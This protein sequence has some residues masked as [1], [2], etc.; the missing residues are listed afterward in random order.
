MP[1]LPP[2]LR[3]LDDYA[4]DRQS[5]SREQFLAAHG[6][7][8]L[9]VPMLSPLQDAERFSTLIVAN[10]AALAPASWAVAKVQKRAGDAFPHFIWVGREVKCD[11][12]LP[13]DGVSKLHAQF[14]LR[15]GGEIDLLDTGSANGTFL[16]G[17]RLQDN[18][19]LRV[20]DGAR[21]QMGMVEMAYRTPEGLWDALATWTPGSRP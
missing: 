14:I 17:K 12:A 20:R 9:I 18:A 13:F 6:T 2:G 4:R 3:P 21:I 1:D 5:T 10:R 7:P 19:P 15:P 16:D 8:V 11:I